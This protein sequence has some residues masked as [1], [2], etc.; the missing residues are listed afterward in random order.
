MLYSII[1][2]FPKKGLVK[3]R[4]TQVQLKY[5]VYVYANSIEFINV[6]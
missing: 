1:E 5:H 3:L 2:D 4:I 6:V